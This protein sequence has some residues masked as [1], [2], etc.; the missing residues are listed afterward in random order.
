MRARRR[1][2]YLLALL[3]IGPLYAQKVSVGLV[4]GLPVTNLLEAR[5]AT[6]SRTSRYTFGPDVRIG[7]RHDL[8]VAINLLYKRAEFGFQS[9]PVRAAVRRLEM[10]IQVRYRFSGLRPRPW[11]QAGVSFNRVV[12][13]TGNDARGEQGLDDRFF[14]LGGRTA[15]EMRH[16]S[17]YGPVLGAGLELRERRVQVDAEVRVTRWV[18]RNFGTRDSPLQSNL[19][20]VEV[21]VGVRF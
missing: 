11:I 8:A 2:L 16:R 1:P 4:A 15:I 21:L 13:I 18:D 6:V 19:T 9:E 14:C 7:M 5:D 3:W 10:P 12:S 17:T 20:Q